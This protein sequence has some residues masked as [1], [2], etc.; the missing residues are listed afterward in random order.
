LASEE[1]HRALDRGY[2]VI[3]EPFTPEQLC[4]RLTGLF[5]SP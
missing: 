5:G 1:A 3:E 2:A 4:H